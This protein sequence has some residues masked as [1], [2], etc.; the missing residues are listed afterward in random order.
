MNF[1]LKVS[2]FFHDLQLNVLLTKTFLD[3]IYIPYY[4]IIYIYIYI[5]IIWNIYFENIPYYIYI[6]MYMTC[7]YTYDALRDLV[8]NA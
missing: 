5:Y 1:L 2:R 8:P 6:Y 3:F 7:M 4:I